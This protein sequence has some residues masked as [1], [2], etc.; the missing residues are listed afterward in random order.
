MCNE[1]EGLIHI[2]TA[3]KSETGVRVLSRENKFKVK[4]QLQLVRNTDN[5]CQWILVVQSRDNLW[6]HGHRD[7]WGPI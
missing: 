5:S 2:R 3:W 1:A 4:L 6:S 7:I